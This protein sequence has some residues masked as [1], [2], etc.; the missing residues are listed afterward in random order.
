MRTIV[1]RLSLLGAMLATL[2][3]VSGCS[4]SLGY[5][6]RVVSA[7]DHQITVTDDDGHE[8]QSHE[9][10]A[11]A[12]ITLDGHPAALEDLESGDAVEITVEERE[13]RELATHVIAKSKVTTND[14]H[15]ASDRDLLPL[16][17]DPAVDSD[18]ASKPDM[19]PSLDDPLNDP[20]GDDDTRTQPVSEVIIVGTISSLTE[21]GFMVRDDAGAD[22]AITVNED[23]QFLLDGQPVAF[24]DLMAEF[25]VTV[26]AEREGEGE[27][28]IASKVEATKITTGSQ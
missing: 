15:D 1:S 5:N 17:P 14:R 19:D 3:L 2:P 16:D 21:S 12:E 9:V 18:L 24:E 25:N 7:G 27:A 26:T 11:D 23:T 28:F 20:V 13:G 6:F 22:Q 10:A 4:E 8:L